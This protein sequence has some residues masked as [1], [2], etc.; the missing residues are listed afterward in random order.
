MAILPRA[1]MA[2]VCAGVNLSR[3]HSFVRKMP[4]TMRLVFG[5]QLTRL[6][7]SEAKEYCPGGSGPRAL[8]AK[9]S[10]SGLFLQASLPEMAQAIVLPPACGSSARMNRRPVLIV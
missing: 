1:R 5:P 8:A 10:G 6:S 2:A 9:Q 3:F 7:L 4:A